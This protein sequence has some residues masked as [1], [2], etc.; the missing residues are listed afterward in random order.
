MCISGDEDERTAADHQAY[1]LVIAK[2]A[3]LQDSV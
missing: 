3:S 2:K 1:I